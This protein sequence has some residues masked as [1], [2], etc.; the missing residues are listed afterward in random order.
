MKTDR[1]VKRRNLK[2]ELANIK[3]I[4][5]TSRPLLEANARLQQAFDAGIQSGYKKRLEEEIAEA[6]AA[7]D[8]VKITPVIAEELAEMKENSL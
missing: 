3:A 2:Q 7:G 5:S 1:I 6:K 4:I 8:S